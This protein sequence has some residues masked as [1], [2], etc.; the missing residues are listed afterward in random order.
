MEEKKLSIKITVNMTDKIMFDFLLHHTYTHLSGLFGAFLGVVGLGLGIHSMM[1]GDTTMTYVGFLLAMMFLIV[2]PI[3]LK[4][5]AKAQVKHSQMF[6]KPLEYE[7]TEEGIIVRQDGVEATST[8]A[9]FEK[10]INTNQSIV[11]YITRMR[12]LIFPKKSMGE[13]YEAIIKMIH[14]HMPPAK[15]K[16]KQ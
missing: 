6:Q 5:R 12:A 7:F 9:E 10:A 15:V 3:Q 2:N 8:W 13:E 4:N 16:I 1:Q 14:T 11:L